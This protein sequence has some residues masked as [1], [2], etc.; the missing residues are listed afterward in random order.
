MSDLFHEDV[1]LDFIQKVFDVMNRCPQHIFQVLTKRPHLTARFAD[2]LNWTPNIWMGT[3]VEDARVTYRV[4]ELRKVPAAIRFLSVEPLLGPIPQLPVKNI[5]VDHCR[6]RVRPRCPADRG[7]MG[8][9]DQGPLRTLRGAV[10][11]QT[12]GRGE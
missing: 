11:L 12:V 4:H 9:A 6:R 10:L 8:P 1:P 2:R 5:H 7:K 3:S